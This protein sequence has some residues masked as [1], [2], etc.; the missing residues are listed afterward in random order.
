MPTYMLQWF[1]PTLEEDT[2]LRLSQGLT[3]AA[4]SLSDDGISIR[5]LASAVSGADEMAF[6]VLEA[7]SVEAAR[8]VGT[9]A[10][11]VIERVTEA[12]FT[13]GGDWRR[14]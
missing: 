1:Q 2:F 10:R 3:Q 5:H 9:R 13:R 4:A 8:E 11:L 6:C 12:L 7:P 14:T